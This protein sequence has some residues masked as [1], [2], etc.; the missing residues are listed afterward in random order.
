[1]TTIA[2]TPPFRRAVP[3]PGFV[4]DVDIPAVWLF[5]QRGNRYT[6]EMLS[7]VNV[8]GAIVP[9]CWPVQLADALRA[10]ERRGLKS[11]AQ[12]DRFLADLPHFLIR[13]DDETSTR[14]WF[15]VL[16]LARVHRVSVFD[17]AYLELARRL[18][19]PLATIDATLRRAA[20]A[21]GVPLFTP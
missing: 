15:D 8:A 20:A 12:V 2:P 19:L 16:G 7:R 3:S 9:G 11:A 4:L 13:I 6:S 17:A 5:S 10:G 18:G 1:V 21:A 14:A